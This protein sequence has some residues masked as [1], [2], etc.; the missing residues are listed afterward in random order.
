MLEQFLE[1]VLASDG[2][3]GGVGHFLDELADPSGVVSEFVDQF[4]GVDGAVVD[5][6]PDAHGDIVL[7]DD[8]LGGQLEDVCFQIHQDHV[9]GAGVNQV[10]ARVQLVD[11]SAE[12]LVDA[13][14]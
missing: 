11:V 13:H 5:H 14:F 9:F 6:S 2:P 1:G 3:H 12:G 4:V 7:G 10:E 8:L